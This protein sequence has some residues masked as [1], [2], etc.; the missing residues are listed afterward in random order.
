LR[1]GGPDGPVKAENFKEM[2]EN[3]KT[4]YKHYQIV[5]AK[6]VFEMFMKR[7]EDGLIEDKGIQADL[8][9]EEFGMLSYVIV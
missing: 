3:M 1:I 8:T 9:K 7:K 5:I 2:K 6:K 4:S